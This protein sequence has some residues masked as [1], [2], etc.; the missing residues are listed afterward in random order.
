[1]PLAGLSLE[2]T[3]LRKES[4]NLKI[5]QQRLLKLKMKRKAATG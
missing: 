1:M 5:V 4:V 2:L 3:Q